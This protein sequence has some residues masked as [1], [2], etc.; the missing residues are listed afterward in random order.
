MCC[1]LYSLLQSSMLFYYT[2]LCS[3]FVCLLD[4]HILIPNTMDNVT[5][6]SSSL[7]LRWLGSSQL[8]KTFEMFS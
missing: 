7:E 4:K 8:F 2:T 1:T 5:C 6:I 3:D